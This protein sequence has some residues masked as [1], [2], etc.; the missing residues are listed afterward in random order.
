[1]KKDCKWCGGFDGVMLQNIGLLLFR[2]VVGVYMITHGWQ[3]LSNFSTISAGFPDP[4][5]VGSSASL[6]LIVFAEFGCSILL[7]LG[8]FTRIATIP[9]IIGM[10]VASFVVK[11]PTSFNQV[12]LSTLYLL[13]YVA[14]TFLGAGKYSLD[15]VLGIFCDKHCK[16]CTDMQGDDKHQ[17][18]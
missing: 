17:V 16:K 8:F 11:T 12:E 10:V 7:I 5:G 14:L 15:Y 2:V 6:A 9:L 3:K 1:M 18:K 13:L 4:L